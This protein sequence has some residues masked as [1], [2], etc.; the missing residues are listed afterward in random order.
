MK[1]LLLWT[2]LLAAAVSLKAESVYATFEAEG[3][4]HASLSLQA[5]GVI[6]AVYADVGSRVEKG[7]L[8]LTL[9]SREQT[10]LVRAAEI[11][12]AQAKNRY[13]R[14]KGLKETLSLEEFEGYE[15]A[16]LKAEA[17]L[18]YQQALLDN[19]MLRA[20]FGGVIAARHVHPGDLIE[21][22][23]TGAFELVDDSRI[24]LVISFDQRYQAQVK[25][26]MVY[27]FRVD[28]GGAKRTAVIESV[29]PTVDPATRKAKA[30]AYV[31]G[32][33]HG[34]FGEGQINPAQ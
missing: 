23:Q 24:K 30:A 17:N 34:L 6:E 4:Q 27:E 10:Q 33:V 31:T 20:P 16:Y 26:G 5:Q 12:Y 7:A 18:K 32:V 22:A 29:Y 15:A 13:E 28:G 1:K 14:F 2:A 3:A 25:P 19:R 9:E 8:L 11:D 21:R